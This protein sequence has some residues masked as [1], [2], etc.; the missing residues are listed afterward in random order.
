MQSLNQFPATKN[1][2]QKLMAYSESIY[3]TIVEERI[4]KA[5]GFERMGDRFDQISEAHAK[6]FDWIL[7]RSNAP[8]AEET[9]PLDQISFAEW[10]AS[11]NGIFH[12]SGKLGSGKS[13]LMK[14]LC[15]DDRTTGYLRIW[16]GN[17]RLVFAKFFFW[18]PGT[19]LQKSLE[20]LYRSILFSIAKECPEL[21]STVFPTLLDHAYSGE[22]LSYGVAA[23]EP[24]VIRSMF[25]H[26]ISNEDIYKNICFCFFIDGLDEYEETP[27]ADYQ[28]L[29]L[30]LNRWTQSSPAGIKIC[31]SSREWNVFEKAFS[32][33]QKLRLQDLT[34]GDIQIYIK[35][36]FDDLLMIDEDK[37]MRGQVDILIQEILNKA[38]GVFLWVSLVVQALRQGLQNGDRP[39]DLR[40]KLHHIPDD[41]ID[42]YRY[43]LNT[44]HPADRAKAYQTFAVAL[45]VS[46]REMMDMSLF[47]FSFLEDFEENPRFLEKAGSEGSR[48]DIDGVNRRVE[49]V[50]KRLNGCCRCLVEARE[51][52]DSF[53]QG[54]LRFKM[55]FTHRSVYEFFSADA[56]QNT[57]QYSQRSLPM[58]AIL[59]A[60]VAEFAFCSLK[61]IDLALPNGL[62]ALC[63]AV[64]EI[65]EES[66]LEHHFEIIDHLHTAV[67]ALQNKQDLD[68]SI[69]HLICSHLYFPISAD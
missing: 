31:V 8:P 18:R 33:E 28:D 20:G 53:R 63:R 34:R 48:I 12:I 49:Y 58:G 19:K 38:D 40:R 37:E 55:T 4:L 13:T 10:L 56:Q 50:K 59:S 54:P 51:V 39:K 17:R 7:E 52:W 11:G 5:I 22:K 61:L 16:A 60:Y 3:Q 68:F 24:Q 26:I 46:Q 35:E 25:N 45:E 6:T 66:A 30:L 29:V 21:I 15:S 36:R 27:Q 44:I 62:G 9:Q 64:R 1:Q 69:V 14:F 43:L 47:Q 57:A 65:V 32:K 23:L 41:L 67:M 42:L 2:L